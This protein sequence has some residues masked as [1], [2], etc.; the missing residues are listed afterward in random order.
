MRGQQEYGEGERKKRDKERTRIESERD[1]C[2]LVCLEDVD[3]RGITGARQ[4][5][6]LILL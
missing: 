5:K 2:S 1:G 3:T 6:A 4:S